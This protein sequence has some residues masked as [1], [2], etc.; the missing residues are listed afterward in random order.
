LSGKDY[1]KLLEI[2][3]ET[4]DKVKPERVSELGIIYQKII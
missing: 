1:R 2:F 4:P 3:G